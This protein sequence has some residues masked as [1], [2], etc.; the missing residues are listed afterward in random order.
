MATES[1]GTALVTGASS[2]IGEEFARQLAAKRYDVVLAARRKDRLDAIASEI[3]EAHGT[4]TE[5]IEAD[6]STKKGVSAVTDRIKKGDI[7]VLVNSAGLGTSGEF[8]QLPL[9]R[10]T[11]ELNVTSSRSHS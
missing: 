9:N 2:G 7:V 11:Q 5:V 8:A 1:K 6:L 3:S 10:E 4:K